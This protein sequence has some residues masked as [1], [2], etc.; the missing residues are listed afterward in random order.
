M[1]IRVFVFRSFS[2]SDE[3]NSNLSVTELKPDGHEFL[4]VHSS[5]SPYFIVEPTAN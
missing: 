4:S 1:I 3:Y 5:G 2:Q